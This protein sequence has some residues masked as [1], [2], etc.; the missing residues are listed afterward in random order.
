MGI[1]HRSCFC[2][3][4][5]MNFTSFHSNLGHSVSNMPGMLQIS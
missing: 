2:F 1:A 4:G 3:Y 5:K